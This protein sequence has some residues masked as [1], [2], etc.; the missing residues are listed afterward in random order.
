MRDK[1]QLANVEF[2]LG[3]CKVLNQRLQTATIELRHLFNVQI[4]DY[5]ALGWLL[6]HKSRQS[7]QHFLIYG[8]LLIK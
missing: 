1:S 6:N 3:V 8:V 5:G 7:L 4:I 2:F